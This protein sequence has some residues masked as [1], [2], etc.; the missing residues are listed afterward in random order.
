MKAAVV[1]QGRSWS[2]FMPRFIINWI[3]SKDKGYCN[4]VEIHK[5]ILDE[6]KFTHLFYLSVIFW[7]VGK[8]VVAET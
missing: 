8:S 1:E 5:N 7:P 3:Y 2:C 4:K 6:P